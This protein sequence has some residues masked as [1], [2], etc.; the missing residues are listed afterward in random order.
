MSTE[1]E[2][3]SSRGRSGGPPGS[4]DAVKVL[5]EILNQVRAGFERPPL[6]QEA[7]DAIAAYNNN[8][9]TLGGKPA[10]VK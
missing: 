8:R 4:D 2:S 3:S 10:P 1:Y 7:K 6:S 9:L 5:T